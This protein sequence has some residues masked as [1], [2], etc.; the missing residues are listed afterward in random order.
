LRPWR[1]RGGG[2]LFAGDG[3]GQPHDVLTDAAWRLREYDERDA[4]IE[5]VDDGAAVGHDGVIDLAADRALDV[6]T[7][8][9]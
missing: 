5:R 2:F 3:L 8:M 7:R 4:A 9:P 6:L 1:R